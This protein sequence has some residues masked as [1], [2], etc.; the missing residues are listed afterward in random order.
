MSDIIDWEKEFEEYN[1]ERKKKINKLNWWDE[2]FE[3][4]SPR[5]KERI[6]IN[7]KKS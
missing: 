6:R 5:R 1:K 4:Y 2:E 3:E 7:K